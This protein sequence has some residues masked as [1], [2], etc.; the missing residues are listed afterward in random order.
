MKHCWCLL[1]SRTHHLTTWKLPQASHC[2]A[3]GT[4]CKQNA[5]LV[6]YEGYCYHQH[7]F[8]L[9]L[10]SSHVLSSSCCGTVLLALANMS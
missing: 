5:L 8:G 2:F 4:L 1:H 9:L 7:H 6:V 3:F 10:I